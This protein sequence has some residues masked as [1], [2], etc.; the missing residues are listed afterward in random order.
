MK[1][2]LEIKVYS[3]IQIMHKMYSASC[4]RQMILVIW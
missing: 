3:K 1:L 4:L 2:V